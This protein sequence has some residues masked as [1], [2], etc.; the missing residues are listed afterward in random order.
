MA[1]QQVAASILDTNLRG[2]NAAFAAL[3]LLTAAIVI[4]PTAQAQTFTVLH[5]FTG[6]DGA[7][8]QAAPT[9]DRV[10]N[11]YG[12]TYYG[13]PGGDGLVYELAHVNSSWLMK[14]LHGFSRGGNGGGEPYAGVTI[15]PDGTLFGVASS[16]GAYDFGT[17]FNVK[18]PAHACA[19]VLCPWSDT[20]LHAFSGY[21]GGGEG[22]GASP[23]GNV[24]FDSQGNLYGTTELG[25]AYNG[26]TVYKA[27]RSAGTWNESVIYSFGAS[28]NDGYY[29]YSGVVLNSAGNI[30]GTTYFGGTYNEGTV[31]ELSPSQGGWTETI[32]HSF[33]GSDGCVPYAGLVFNQAGN[34][35]GATDGYG[36]ID[37]ATIFE[38]SPQGGSWNFTTIYG[39]GDGVVATLAVDGAGDLYGTT[40]YG[41][42]YAY[43]EVFELSP[44]SGG[45]RYTHLYDFTG[46]NDGGYPGG[47]AVTGQGGYLYG[48][49]Y[50]GGANGDGV[51]Y[52]ISLGA[53]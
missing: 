36:C 27:S 33:T 9:L 7:N 35:Y 10:G 37:G 21:S 39:T 2:R 29:T 6:R 53:K 52:Q 14:P 16:Y 42:P 25:G 28:E 31:Y 38:L 49:T 4:I 15:G 19:S 34:L 20:T 44:S 43:G 48:T 41:G 40:F 26:G 32:L 18:P 24:V 12:T 1:Q 13:G 8:P 3:A 5:T 17:L 46:S 22:D 50:S 51:I 30:Y 11:L 47:V 45:W 23:Y